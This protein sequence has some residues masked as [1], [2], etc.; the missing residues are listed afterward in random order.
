MTWMQFVAAVAWPV[1]VVAIAVMY[2]RPI[3]GLIKNIGEIAARA[4]R[5]SFELAFG[6]KF[7]L[8]FRDR[9]AEA[10]VTDKSEIIKVA[11]EAVAEVVSTVRE[12][13]VYRETERLFG[14]RPERLGETLSAHRD[15]VGETGNAILVALEFFPTV[16]MPELYRVVNPNRLELKR[17]FDRLI[18]RRLAW[19]PGVGR[20]AK[21]T[22]VGLAYLGWLQGA[23]PD[24]FNRAW[25]KWSPER[26]ATP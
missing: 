12:P 9:L 13:S 1:A 10:D 22:G 15:A 24:E 26:E 19:K 6:E 21:V 14:T 18:E 5:E 25:G 2:R 23:H 4:S 11:D 3:Y 16:D 20:R 8:I 7:R 17:D